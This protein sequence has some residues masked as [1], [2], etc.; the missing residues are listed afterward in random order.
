MRSGV[1]HTAVFPVSRAPATIATAFRMSREAAWNPYTPAASALAL[2]FGRGST[3]VLGAEVLVDLASI[4]VQ[5]VL[6][7]TSVPFALPI[8]PL[9]AYSGMV[10]TAQ[11]LHL[12]AGNG[13]AASRG[14]TLTLQ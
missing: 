6:S 13:L 11:S 8:P 7:G 3:T 2:S 4:V 14:L 5:F 10:L 1:L 12:E 9:P